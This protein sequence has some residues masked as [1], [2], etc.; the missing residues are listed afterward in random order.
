MMVLAWLAACWLSGVVAIAVASQCLPERDDYFW[1]LHA[2]YV[3]I[4][5]RYLDEDDEP[6]NAMQG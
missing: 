2:L 5:G 6:P 3:V 4:Y 1:P